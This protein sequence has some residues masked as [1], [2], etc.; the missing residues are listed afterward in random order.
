M[1]HG[2]AAGNPN[3]PTIT[4]FGVLTDPL[5]SLQPTSDGLLAVQTRLRTPHPIAL[6]PHPPGIWTTLAA[7]PSGRLT[8]A[9]FRDGFPV[10][11]WKLHFVEHC[12]F[13]ISLWTTSARGMRNSSACSATDE[14]G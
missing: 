1:F 8:L 7:N 11:L 12:R 14:F 2:W 6:W 3:M 9:G 13:K 4:K 5:T 10:D